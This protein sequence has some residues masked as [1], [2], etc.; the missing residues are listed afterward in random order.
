YF[1][2][3]YCGYPHIAFFNELLKNK[4]MTLLDVKNIK[5]KMS[6]NFLIA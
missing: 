1:K 2:Q 3:I 6:Y 4:K 5:L